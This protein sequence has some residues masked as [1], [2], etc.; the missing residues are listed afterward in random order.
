MAGSR[1]WFIYEADNG[2]KFA[3]QLD[4]SN[5]EA[6]GFAHYTDTELM[7]SEFDAMPGVGY[8][9]TPLPTNLEMRY[10]NCIGKFTDSV[11]NSEVTKSTRLPIPNHAKVVT[12]MNTAG[13]RKL[14]IQEILY[15]GILQEIQYL[16][17]GIVGEVWRNLPHTFD[18]GQND[19]DDD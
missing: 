7:L 10:V 5:A 16:V 11:T 6:M 9:I 14:P 18:T 3:I 12:I 15:N 4:E 2:T 8:T 17:T 13:A 19:G 1:Q